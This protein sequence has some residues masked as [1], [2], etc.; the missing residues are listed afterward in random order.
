[1]VTLFFAANLCGFLLALAAA[2]HRHRY[3]LCRRLQRECD[4]EVLGV[5]RGL[6]PKSR[7]ALFPLIGSARASAPG[8]DSVRAGVLVKSSLIRLLIGGGHPPHVRALATITNHV[9]SAAPRR[10]ARRREAQG[11]PSGFSMLLSTGT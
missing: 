11:G 3:F 7:Q 2:A 10:E 1:M 8:L 6:T 5:C 4:R 9:T